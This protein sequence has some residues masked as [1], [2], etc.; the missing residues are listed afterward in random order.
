MHVFQL[1]NR[2][3][4]CACKRIG[5]CWEHNWTYFYFLYQKHSPK[6]DECLFLVYKHYWKQEYR[7]FLSHLTFPLWL[8]VL[9]VN[10]GFDIAPNPTCIRLFIIIKLELL[11]HNTNIFSSFYP[12]SKSIR[13][14]SNFYTQILLTL[15]CILLFQQIFLMLDNKNAYC[16]QY[17]RL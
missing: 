4:D 2:R 11:F 6:I 8:I 15:F 1:R 5:A 14:K 17:C 12:R 16:S 7:I 13:Y 9:Y 10:T 3:A